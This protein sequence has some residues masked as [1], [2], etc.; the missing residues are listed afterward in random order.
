MFLKRKAFV[1]D[2]LIKVYICLFLNVLYGNVRGV[3]SGVVNGKTGRVLYNS[4]NGKRYSSG[5]LHRLFSTH[6]FRF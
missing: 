1:N 5:D 4:C 3:A 6:T 2:M